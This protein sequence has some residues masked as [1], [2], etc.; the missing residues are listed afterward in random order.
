MRGFHGLV[1]RHRVVG[2][3]DNVFDPVLEGEE[4]ARG[5]NAQERCGGFGRGRGG[6]YRGSHGQ[7]DEG[8]GE[9][10]HCDGLVTVLFLVKFLMVFL[11]LLSVLPLV[12]ILV[13]KTGV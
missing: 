7:G 1:D 13:L 3:G 10:D 11:V 8:E 9:V 5:F 6:G 12:V 2:V 4:R